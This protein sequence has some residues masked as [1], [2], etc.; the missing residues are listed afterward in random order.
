MNKE[1]ISTFV[2]SDDK[3]IFRKTFKGG[4]V[5]KIAVQNKWIE[6]SL[7]I[8]INPSFKNEEP[9]DKKEIRNYLKDV[10]EKI[11]LVLSDQ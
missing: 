4:S 10:K 8:T 11:V 6:G 2:E 1:N 5:V 3:I 9:S 7:A